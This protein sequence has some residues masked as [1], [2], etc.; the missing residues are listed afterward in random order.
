MLIDGSKLAQTILDNL[1][2]QVKNL[3]LKNIN[4]G[5]AV[6]LVGDDPASKAYVKRKQKA[7]EKIGIIFHS[8]LFE[9]DV[10]KETLFKTIDWLNKDKDVHGIIVQLPLPKNLDEKKI[11]ERV[12]PKK[13]IDG[14][15][16]QTKF[17]PP[18]SEAV[19]EVLKSINVDPKDKKV[20][21]IGRGETAGKP[22]ANMFIQNGAKVTIVNSKTENIPQITKYADIIVSCVGKKDVVTEDMVNKDTILIGVGL[23]REEDGKLYGDYDESKIADKVAFYTPTPGGMGPLNVTCLLKNVLQATSKNI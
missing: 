23:H 17:F 20:V 21:V 12:D 15:H 11:G 2:I 9:N 1:D 22:I 13:D 16:P 10:T 14:F 19:L 3:Q 6:I 7:A 8:Y 5:F 18:I 4:P